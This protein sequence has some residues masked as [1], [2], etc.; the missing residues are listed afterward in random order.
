MAMDFLNRH[1]RYR[2]ADACSVGLTMSNFS[3]KLTVECTNYMA[4]IDAALFSSL[5]V[6]LSVATLVLPTLYKERC[7]IKFHIYKRLSLSPSML[8]PGL[9]TSRH[10]KFPDIS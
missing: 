4:K 8:C 7:A 1:A 3:S 5:R 9:P 2:I 6:Q 10:F